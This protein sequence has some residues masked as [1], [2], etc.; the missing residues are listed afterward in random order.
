MKKLFTL[1]LFLLLASLYACERPQSIEPS[2][3]SLPL[4]ASEVTENLPSLPPVNKEVSRDSLYYDTM[5]TIISYYEEDPYNLE[6][7]YFTVYDIDSDG[8]EE[9][10]LGVA[11]SGDVHLASIYAMQNGVGVRQEEFFT[12]DGEGRSYFPSFVYKNGTARV[13]RLD[14]AGLFYYYYRFEDGALKRKIELMKPHHR[15]EYYRR[16]EDLS[17]DPPGVNQ[18]PLTKEEFEQTMKEME[19]DGQVELDWKPLAEYGR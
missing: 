16:E 9:L 12:Y 2:T 10:L 3:P 14:D 6:T 13:E 5:E 19:G 7:R 11:E 18:I 15:D 8:T 4:L 17:K 1:L